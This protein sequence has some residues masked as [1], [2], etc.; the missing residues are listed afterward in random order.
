MDQTE[1]LMEV[2]LIWPWPEG[3]RLVFHAAQQV[4]KA[5]FRDAMVYFGALQL[6]PWRTM[7]EEVVNIS[8]SNRVKEG[9]A[10]VGIQRALCDWCSR[11]IQV[12]LRAVLT[13]I[14]A[15][16]FSLL[17]E[18]DHLWCLSSFQRQDLQE[19]GLKVFSKISQK[20]NG[21]C[22]REETKRAI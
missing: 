15:W 1:R 22:R 17:V 21:Y 4:A 6:W 16:T 13:S 5:S 20:H 3:G 8:W 10:L 11:E 14:A 7:E 18:V 19:R 9:Q 2:V 12:D